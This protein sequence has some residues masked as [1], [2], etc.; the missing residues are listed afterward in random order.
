MSGRNPVSRVLGFLWRMLERM[1]KVAQLLIYLIILVGFLTIISGVT[2]RGVDVPESSALVLGLS[3]MLVEDYEGEAFDRA[4]AELQGRG[5]AQTRV[6][7]VVSALERASEDERIDVVV[8]L[9]DD[10]A[11]ASVT[12]LQSVGRAIATFRESG[13][14]VVAMGEGYTQAQYYL[15]AQADEVYMHDFGV[16]FIEGFGYFRIYFADALEKLG[17]EI[18]VFRV[19]EYKSFVEPYLRNDMSSEDREASEAWLTALWEAY[20]QDIV[21]SRE[22]PDGALADYSN[23][24]V[25]LL[26]ATDG[27]TA[28]AAL[29][30]GLVD[31]LMSHQEFDSYMIG[32]VGEDED[33]TGDFQAIDF[34]SYLKAVKFEQPEPAFEQNVA[35][36]IASGTIV[37]GEAPPGTIGGTT[38]AAKVREAALDEN[39][40]AVVL[41]VDSPGGSMFASEVVF[42]QLNQ[43]KA[44]GKP[45]IASMG[46][47]A[48]SG[49]YYI[50]MPA[51]EIWANSTTISGSIGVGAMFPTVQRGL[52]KLGV[53]IDGFGTTSLAGQLSPAR[54]LGADARQLLQLSTQNAYD[55]FIGKVADTREMSVERVDGIA[56]GRVWIGSDALE[57]GLVDQLGDIDE[58]VSA[59][60]E[61]AGLAEGE[62][63]VIYPEAKLSPAE[64]IILQYARLLTKFAPAWLDIFG[65]PAAPGVDAVLDTLG[66]EFARL[67]QWNDPRGLYYHCF[68]EIN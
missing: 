61:H 1:L 4:F 44:M 10:L 50:S 18:N 57:I 17:V 23:D 32:L 19:G 64:R 7:D 58:A 15:A 30:A 8:L 47:V 38:F 51:D 34:R 42:D 37:D 35:V 29:D 52:Q 33:E 53:N 36:L 49:G 54:E 6:R 41:R 22:L 62:Y 46:S 9:L 67:A 16:V 12:K 24:L 59:A 31:G 43:L 60:A 65:R 21:D 55:T 3:G 2:P 66:R 11:G 68:C 27:D 28:Q 14:K 48:A 45:L 26:S 5:A 20:Q 39:V 25:A 13:K 63:G 40:Q 56:R